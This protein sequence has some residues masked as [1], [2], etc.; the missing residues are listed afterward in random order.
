MG[1]TEPHIR[2]IIRIFTTIDAAF[3]ERAD[4]YVGADLLVYYEQNSP[5]AVVVS[6]VMA[7]VGASKLPYRR[8]YKLWEEAIPPTFVV[9]VTSRSSRDTDRDLKPD[10]YR[11]MGVQEHVLYD[12]IDEYLSPPL[13][14]YRLTGDA[15]EPML[16]D[17]DGA[18][19]SEALG[20]TVR[21]VDGRL[22]L[23]VHTTGEPLLSHEECAKAETDARQAAEAAQR[24]AEVSR[25]EAEARIAQL[26]AELHRLREHAQ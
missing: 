17:P 6:D 11:R 14:G 5:G 9:E 20:L 10:L 26:E 8:T 18:L 13:R 24:T 4:V 22:R 19:V 15:Y 1:E 25:Q 16:A 23:F 21:L 7:A 2:E 12:P 3:V